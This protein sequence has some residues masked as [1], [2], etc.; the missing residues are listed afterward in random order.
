MTEQAQQPAQ[1]DVDLTFKLSF[2]NALI[3]SLDEIPHKWS[4]PIIDAL[5]RAANE[6]LQAMQQSQQPEGSLG[7]KVIQ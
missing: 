6:Q 2:I 1:Q 4:R 5:G 7:N 3:Q